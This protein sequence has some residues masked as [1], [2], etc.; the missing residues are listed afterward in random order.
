M[1]K[2]VI[3]DSGSMFGVIVMLQNKFGTGFG[4][5]RLPDG[6]ASW[7]RIQTSKV[8]KTFAQYCTVYTVYIHS[9]S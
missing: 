7:I 5:R 2:I 9:N 6:T 8:P 4:I 1:S 3:V